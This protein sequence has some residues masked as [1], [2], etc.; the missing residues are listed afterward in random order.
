MGTTGLHHRR[1]DPETALLWIILFG[2]HEFRVVLFDTFCFT[3]TID[4]FGLGGFYKLLSC[5][6]VKSEFKSIMWIVLNC[7]QVKICSTGT[8]RI[9][10]I[11]CDSLMIVLNQ[12]FYKL[13]SC[14]FLMILFYW[15]N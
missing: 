3:G 2:F 1:A 4:D 10:K 9:L 12:N 8:I 13:F 6:C 11:A 14:D 7:E 15:Y 5:D